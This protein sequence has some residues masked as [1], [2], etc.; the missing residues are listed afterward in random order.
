MKD[1][2]KGEKDANWS[3]KT[4]KWTNEKCLRN[5]Q[6]NERRK[7]D[8]E[9]VRFLLMNC[10]VFKKQRKYNPRKKNYSQ[11]VQEEVSHNLL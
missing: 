5:S 8:K 9:R 11:I 10:S 3:Q 2:K 7:G 1:M 4:N 6:G